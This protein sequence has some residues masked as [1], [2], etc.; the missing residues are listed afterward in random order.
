MASGFFLFFKAQLP[1]KIFSVEPIVNKNVVIDSLLLQAVADYKDSSLTTPDTSSGKQTQKQSSSENNQDTTVEQKE[2]SP[3]SKDGFLGQEDFRGNGFTNTDGMDNLEYF[4]SQLYNLQQDPNKSVRIAYYGDSMTDGD[5]IVQDLRGSFQ[6]NFSGNGVGF[7]PMTNESSRSRASIT[8]R[9]S[10]NW[11]TISYVN[12]RNP[13]RPFGVSGQVFFVKD[14]VN[15]TWVSIAAGGIKHM[16]S[17][18]SPTLYYGKSD[19]KIASVQIIADRDTVVKQLQ[20]NNRLNRLELVKGP[21]KKLEVNFIKADSIAFYGINVGSSKGVQVDNFS[22]RGNSGLPISLL[23]TGLINSFDNY[24]HYDLIILHFGTN[25]L[26]Y[27]SYN[28]SWYTNQMSRV[29]K[30]LQQC[31]PK[32]DILVISTADK[33]TKYETSMQS[34]SAVTPLVNAQKR[35]AEQNNI[36]FFNLYTAMGGEGSMV[37]WVEELPTRANKDYTHFNYKGA[38]EVANLLYKQI[39]QGYLLYQ[40]KREEQKKNKEKQIRLEKQRDSLALAKDSLTIEV[41]NE[42]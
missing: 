5:M 4:Y 17:L 20:P 21:V 7:V 16:R 11:N 18:Y 35:Y 42:N 6:E 19:N 12:N 10:N 31:F 2:Q 25:V 9:Y 38:K 36:A 33:A 15:P 1:N 29:V 40:G 41:S 32:A 13:I 23:S 30:H 39:D 3:K 28:Y 24:L 27:G 22:S 14:S 26:N 8:H 34:D 37:E